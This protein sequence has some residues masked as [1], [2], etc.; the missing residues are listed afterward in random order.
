MKETLK[1]DHQLTRLFETVGTP[2]DDGA[3]VENVL[4]KAS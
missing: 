1:Q 3:P 4:S 2:K